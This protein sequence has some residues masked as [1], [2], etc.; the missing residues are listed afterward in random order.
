MKDGEG[1]SFQIEEITVIGET[2]FISPNGHLHT[3][4]YWI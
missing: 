1:N 2:T 4:P 3:I